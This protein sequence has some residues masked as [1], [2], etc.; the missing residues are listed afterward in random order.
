MRGSGDPQEGIVS[1][2]G[3]Q[4]IGEEQRSLHEGGD[5]QVD[6]KGVEFTLRMQGR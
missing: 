5:I 2:N 1:F 6:Y 4:D 3:V